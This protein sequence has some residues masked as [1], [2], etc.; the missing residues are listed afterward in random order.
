MQPIR[1]EL[2][3]DVATNHGAR[4]SP[5]SPGFGQTAIVFQLRHA[6][7]KGASLNSIV[8]FDLVFLPVLACPL[9]ATFPNCIQRYI[10]Y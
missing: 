1:Q 6:L 3:A 2:S 5:K 9:L 4:G 7:P 8:G 10:T